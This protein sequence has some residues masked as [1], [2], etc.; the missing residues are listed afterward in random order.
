M[1]DRL[2]SR[3]LISSQAEI[4]E[5]T[6]MSQATRFRSLV[7]LLSVTVSIFSLDTSASLGVGQEPSP[8]EAR[9]RVE[10]SQY[11]E[12]FAKKDL[13]NLLRHW[14]AGS[15]E[16]DARKKQLQQEFA[17]NENFEIKNLAIRKLIFEGDKASAQVTLEITATD[18]KTNQPATAFGKM[19]RVLEF[20]KESGF[21]KI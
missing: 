7:I 20:V 13:D 10:V 3:P 9:L 1:P 5:E 12:S 8:D 4:I 11:F 6:P 15:P 16:L 21:W 17:A 2:V 18:I 14:S 19:N